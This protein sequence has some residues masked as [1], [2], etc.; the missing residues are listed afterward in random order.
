[1]KNDKWWTCLKRHGRNS[2][3][4]P[5]HLPGGSEQKCKKCK[6]S[7]SPDLNVFQNYKIRV[8]LP[9]STASH[10][11][12][13]YTLRATKIEYVKHSNSQIG[14]EERMHRSLF[15]LFLQPNCNFDAAQG[16][17]LLPSLKRPILHFSQHGFLDFPLLV[18][19]PKCLS[20]MHQYV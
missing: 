14:S 20:H 1:V 13:H 4:Y 18:I 9:H 7:R 10:N 5:K 6:H 17:T 8:L 3:Y 15:A 11:Q 19:Y 16:P 2:W 12:H